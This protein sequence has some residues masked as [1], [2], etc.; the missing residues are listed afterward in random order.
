MHWLDTE[1]RYGAVSRA[2]HWSMALL[3]LLMLGSDWWMEA[4]EGLGEAAAMTLHQSL[5]MTLLALL[6]FR[7]AWRCA[8]GCPTA[9][10]SPPADAVQPRW[11]AR[12]S[13]SSAQWCRLSSWMV[14]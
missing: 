6:A 8:S 7:L 13:G 2:L 9:P 11:H 3:V 12:G 4:F 14:A 1:H 10:S 5:G